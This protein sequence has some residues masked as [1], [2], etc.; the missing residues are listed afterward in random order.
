ME[1]LK[2]ITT[3]KRL[4]A[5]RSSKINALKSEMDIITSSDKYSQE[6]KNQ[7]S[8]ERKD[9]IIAIQSEYDSQINEQ[10]TTHLTRLKGEFSKAEYEGLS[11]G[12]A[13][14]ALLREMRNQ[15]ETQA[16]IARYKDLTDAG[17][18]E[19][20]QTEAHAKVQ[21]NAADAPAY[22]NAMKQLNIIGADEY[23]QTYKSNNLNKLQKSIQNDI[24][25][26][27]EQK[28]EWQSEQYEAVNPWTE[29]FSE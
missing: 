25:Q 11:D 18:N 12:E 22:I 24:N 1:T 26:I 4:R 20:L 8:R 3:I 6:Y 17:M 29:A 13:T 15:Q 19:A 14:K 28:R 9:E 21:T 16:L 27:E 5:E 7:I 10:I 23:E 2:A